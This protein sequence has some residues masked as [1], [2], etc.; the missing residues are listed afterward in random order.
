[1]DKVYLEMST[2]R[3]VREVEMFHYDT[4]PWTLLILWGLT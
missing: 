4:Y 2:L 1:M 3:R